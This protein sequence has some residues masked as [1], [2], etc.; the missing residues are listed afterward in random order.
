M[1]AG[2][3]PCAAPAASKPLALLTPPGH[4]LFGTAFYTP[5]ASARA[6]WQ[7]GRGA[8]VGVQVWAGAGRARAPAWM[9]GRLYGL[10]CA[11]GGSLVAARH[12]QQPVA[13]V[14]VEKRQATRA[15]VVGW[16]LL[17]VRW[18]ARTGR[19]ARPAQGGSNDTSV[20]GT[21]AAR[22]QPAAQ[23]VRRL[24]AAK[25][26]HWRRKSARRRAPAWWG[27]GCEWTT[28]GSS[29][30]MRPRRGQGCTGVAQVCAWV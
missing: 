24:G 21:G 3:T 4:C 15:G 29:S 8:W 17:R 11:C 2:P 28:N 23:G 20:G 22:A 25:A 13:P 5:S 9:C 26:T 10:C 14:A 7:E 6:A 19:S 12:T 1:W 18:Q 30:L 27:V 16:P